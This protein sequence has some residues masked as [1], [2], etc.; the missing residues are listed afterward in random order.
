MRSFILSYANLASWN[1]ISQNS[2]PHVVL[3]EVKPKKFA[4]DLEGQSD[5]EPCAWGL[6]HWI[7]VQ[8]V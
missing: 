6:A 1:Y 5:T 2:L 3:G 4:W 7:S 8:D